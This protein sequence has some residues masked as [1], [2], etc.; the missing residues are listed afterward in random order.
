MAKRIKSAVK[1]AEIAERNR[2]RNVAVK[3]AAK[4]AVKKAV[5][6]AKSKEG[7][8]A[9]LRAAASALDRAAAK[10]VLHKNAVARKKSRLAKKVAALTA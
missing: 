8:E 9:G 4:T 2:Q 6:A 10:G 1:R 5:D 3:S 7:V